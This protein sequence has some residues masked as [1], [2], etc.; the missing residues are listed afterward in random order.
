ME[1]TKRMWILGNCASHHAFKRYQN[2]IILLFGQNGS[3]TCQTLELK[4][5]NSN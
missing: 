1:V 4:I 5:F 3:D 2:Q